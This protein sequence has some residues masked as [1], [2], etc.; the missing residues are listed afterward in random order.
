MRNFLAGKD[1]HEKESLTS[2]LQHREY[3]EVPFR[4]CDVL[5]VHL[6]G[7]LALPPDRKSKKLLRRKIICLTIS[8]VELCLSNIFHHIIMHQSRLYDY[9][10]CLSLMII[11]GAPQPH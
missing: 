8:K 3:T 7:K 1:H 6:L 2:I 11:I 9:H 4:I 10:Q 5:D